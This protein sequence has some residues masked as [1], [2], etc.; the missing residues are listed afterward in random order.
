MISCHSKKTLNPNSTKSNDLNLSLQNDGVWKSLGPFGSSEPMA[1]SGSLSPHGAGR[2]MCIDIHPKNV[3]E[4]LIGHA[5]AGIFK[6]SDG[7]LHWEQ[8]LNINIATGIFDILRFKQ[9]SKHILVCANL[10]IGP[11]REYGYGLLESFDGGET[12]QRNSLQFNPE[13]YNIE[14][15]FAIEILDKKR[16]EKLICISK[17]KVYLSYDGGKVWNVSYQSDYALKSIV[18]DPSNSERIILSGNGVLISTDAGKTWTD[19]SDKINSICNT[20]PNKFAKYNVCF[21]KKDENL[22]YIAGINHSFSL[23][24]LDL[25]R[26]NKFNLINRNISAHNQNRCEINVLYNTAS[27]IE[28]LYIGSLRLYKSVDQGKTFKQT[29]FPNAKVP[30][31]MHDDINDLYVYG[32][33]A[34]FAC[35][36][37]GVDYTADGGK[38]WSS[39][40]QNSNLNTTILYGFDRSKKGVIVCGSQDNGIFVFKD[41][42]WKC[43]DMYG[44]GGRVIS[45]NDSFGF[46]CGLAQ[47]NYVTYDAGKSFKY[48]HAGK[49]T[50]G[51]D[52]KMQHIQNSNIFYI[53]NMQLYK[54]EIGKYFE[55]LSSSIPTDRKIKSFY[56]EPDNENSIWICKEDA[57]WGKDP[58]NKLWHTTDGGKNWNDMSA[59]LPILKWRSMSDI[60]INRF[61]E[62]AIVFDGFDKNNSTSHRVYISKDLGNSFENISAGLPNLPMTGILYADNRWICSNNSGVYELNDEKWEQ[63]GRGL[64]ACII[65]EIKYYE[66]DHTLMAS[67]FGRGIWAIKL[68]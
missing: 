59:S 49:E 20:Y 26:T 37:G 58:I 53:A 40:T 22:L 60:Y 25:G 67:T 19:V 47:R 8:K 43:A 44:D 57:T 56:V 36:D 46:A 14:Q 7:G 21:S 10:D 61:G 38:T 51:Y 15:C 3:Y 63:L 34:L 30:N 33:S 35:T 11:S 42:Y 65:T 32:S 66:F 9:D 62:I 1:D 13:E 23:L 12:W 39:I 64:P 6:T 2:F 45:L 50:T 31:H 24:S 17:N 5:S 54:K 52:F 28:T 48:E 41:G 68:Q 16:E 29:A 27:D 4:M 18:V 55:L